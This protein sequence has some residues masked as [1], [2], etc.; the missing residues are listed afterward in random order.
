LPI[1]PLNVGNEISFLLW[2]IHVV[3]QLLESLGDTI[4]VYS[5]RNRLRFLQKGFEP[6]RIKGHVSCNDFI[7]ASQQDDGNRIAGQEFLP[8]DPCLVQCTVETR[9]PLGAMLHAEGGIYGQ[10]DAG[11]GFPTE[12]TA[13]TSLPDW[14]GEGEDQKEKG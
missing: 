14:T 4:E 12:P 8:D 10:D 1:P 7:F 2:R 11:P 9:S 3:K 5:G 6:I 13:R